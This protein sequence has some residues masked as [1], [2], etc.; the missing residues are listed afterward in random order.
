MKN[1][2]RGNPTDAA[3]QLTDLLSKGHQKREKLDKDLRHLGGVNFREEIGK[4]LFT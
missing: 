3:P 4:T 2:F 1:Y